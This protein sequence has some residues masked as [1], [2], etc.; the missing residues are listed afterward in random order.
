MDW[1]QL[2]DTIYVWDGGWLDI[3][4]HGT[5]AKDWE[6]WTHYVNQNFKIDW[7]NGKTE[8]DE[9]KI[10]FTVIQEYWDG[11]H[12]LCSTAKVFIDDNIQVNAHFFDDEEIE[13]DIDPREFK[14]IDDHNK[15][16]EFLK[17]LSN[18]LA[19]EVT[20]TP[21]NCPEIVLMKINGESVDIN[22]EGEPKKWPLRIKK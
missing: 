9:S 21:E 19:K 22:L 3:Y 4:V 12:N 20:V 15:L 14:S 13:N 16:I 10:D 18:E 1:N 7:F 5:S 6:K 11:N 17:R 2:K 8:R